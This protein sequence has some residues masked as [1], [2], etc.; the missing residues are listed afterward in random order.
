ML[1]SRICQHRVTFKNCTQNPQGL[2]QLYNIMAR[3][4]PC[5]SSLEPNE[6]WTW[7]RMATKMRPLPFYGTR[8]CHTTQMYEFFAGQPENSVRPVSSD[9]WSGQYMSIVSNRHVLA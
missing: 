4:V 8:P 1:A 9:V 3:S 6:D 2:F 5:P 7:R